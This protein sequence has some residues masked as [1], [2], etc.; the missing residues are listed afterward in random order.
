M[1]SRKEE[2]QKCLSFRPRWR[3]WRDTRKLKAYADF[4]GDHHN[5]SDHYGERFDRSSNQ[6]YK[7]EHGFFFRRRNIEINQKWLEAR[8]KKMVSKHHLLDS[9]LISTNNND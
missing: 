6:L 3:R 7:R 5:K 1:K 9:K 2:I 8:F 4:L